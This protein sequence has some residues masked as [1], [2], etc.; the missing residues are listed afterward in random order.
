MMYLRFLVLLLLSQAVI[1]KA[2]DG[3]GALPLSNHGNERVYIERALKRARI[4]SEKIRADRAPVLQA[5]VLPPALQWPVRKS[6]IVTDADVQAISNFLDQD[7]SEGGILDYDCGDRTYDGHNGLDISL[8]PYSWYMMERDHAIVVAAA[9]GTIVEKVNN[10]PERSCTIDNSGGDNNLVV[11]E[12]QDGSLALYAHM[13]TGSLTSRAVGEKVTTGEYLGVVGSAGRSTGPHL[14][15]EVGFWELNQNVWEW[16]P[17]D[18]FAGTCNDLN[19]E[20]W[21]QEQPDYRISMLN[22]IATHDQAPEFPSCPETEIPHLSD[23]FMPGDTVFLSTYYRDQLNGQNTHLKITRPNGTTFSEWDHAP[24]SG[25]YPAS[26]WYWSISL[27]ANAVSGEWLF[28][29]E[30]EGQ[31]AEHKFYVNSVAAPPP[32]MPAANNAYN[33]AWYDPTRDGEGYNIVTTPSGTVVYFYG[34]DMHGKRLWLISDVVTDVLVAG[35]DVTFV[36]YESTGGS[37]TAPI[38]STRGLSV[39]GEL[40]FNFTDCDSGTARLHGLD[41][42]KS[43]NIVKIAG[44]AGTICVGQ[45]SADGPYAG[46]WFDLASEGEGFNLIV[47]P[48]GAVIYYYG[49]DKKGDR[50]WFIS[51][52]IQTT[53]QAG[54]QVG[55]DLF[56]ATSGTFDAPVPSE[57]ALVKWGTLNIAVVDCEHLNITM[58]TQEGLKV[59]ATFKI[60]GVVGLTCS[61]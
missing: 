4:N 38:T 55:S 45:A 58:N 43:S 44:V 42:Q 50:L 11:I 23:S 32:V 9:P 37:Y 15:F 35:E 22:G 12:Q 17:R 57:Q 40:V 54:Q 61:G 3:G 25:P 59:S 14:H 33:G 47:T 6:I 34:S 2:P 27:P 1:A 24:T 49:F 19:V 28:S 36:M 53:L 13:R 56:K 20:S 26:L 41:G 30:F 31:T 21:W 52:L 48:I 29:V 51:D 8:T 46:A 39:W 5:D 16:K 7:P 10:Q 18:P 60:A